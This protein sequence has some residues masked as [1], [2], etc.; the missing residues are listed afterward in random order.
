MRNTFSSA[1]A[2]S[3]N[4]FKMLRRI[5]LWSM[6]LGCFISQ[7]PI[8]K[9]EETTFKKQW[10]STQDLVL[11]SEDVPYVPLSDAE[12]EARRI[13]QNNMRKIYPKAQFKALALPERNR[14]HSIFLISKDGKTRRLLWQRVIAEF[15]RKSVRDKDKK[16]LNMSPELEFFDISLEENQIVVVYRRGFQIIAEVAKQGATFSERGICLQW[17][18]PEPDPKMSI[19]PQFPIA[20]AAK[21]VGSLKNG[22]LMVI[23]ETYAGTKRYEWKQESWA[24]KNEVMN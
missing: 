21:I 22:D 23:A 17:S 9:A 18:L 15:E 7:P 1:I 12:L 11:L 24:K 16:T 13:E 6:L 4:E 3:S 2:P 14:R 20:K 19:S 8:V 10:N 5:F